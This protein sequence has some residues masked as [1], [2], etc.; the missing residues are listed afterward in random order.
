MDSY[1]TKKVIAGFEIKSISNIDKI[2]Q[3]VYQLEHQKTGAQMVHLANND[4]HNAFGVG[5]LTCPQDSSGIAHI[6]E[7]I[8]LCGSKHF[9]L[10]DPFFSMLKRS[11]ASFMNAFTASDWTMY[12][13]VTQNKKDFYHLLDVY[14]DAVFYPLLKESSFLQEAHRLL[15]ENKKWIAQGVVFN[16]MKGAMS[17]PVEIMSRR[18]LQAVFPSITYHYNS[19]GEPVN[20][21]DLN[22]QS[23]KEF[24]SKYYHPSN[25]KFFSYGSFDLVEK[26]EFLDK[27]ILQNYEKLADKIFI[28]KE[29]RFIS[30]QNFEYY[31]PVAK[32]DHS[33]YQLALNWLNCSVTD[34]KEVLALS[35]LSEILLGSSA[36]PLRFRLVES[37]LGK[38]LADTTGY[39]ED[40][41]ETFFSV[42]LKGIKKQDLQKVENLIL[43]TLQDLAGS[44][45]DKFFIDSAIHQKEI[46]MK[47][48]S[49]S[50]YPYSLNLLFRFIGV[51]MNQGD[52]IASLNFDEALQAI[53]EQA[54]KSNYFEQ[55]ITKHL[56]DNRHRVKVLLK[57]QQEYLLLQDAKIEQKIQQLTKNIE[58]ASKQATKRVEDLT[59]LPC[60]ELQEVNLD[61]PALKIQKHGAFSSS[62]QT[63]NDIEYWSL[64]LENTTTDFLTSKDAAIITSMLTEI[65]TQNFRY[66]QFTAQ[67][68][69]YTGGLGFAPFFSN[70][71]NSENY[72]QLLQLSAKSLVV[73]KKKMQE[74]IAEVL[75]NYSFVNLARIR[76]WLEQITL[77]KTTSLLHQGHYYAQNLACRNFSVIL[78]LAESQFGIHS[79]A[80]LKE[81]TRFSNEKLA[82]LVSKFE[83][84]WSNFLKGARASFCLVGDNLQN[85]QELILD[86]GLKSQEQWSSLSNRHTQAPLKE[87]W[88]MP[89]SVSFVARAYLTVK[90]DHLDSPL[91]LLLAKLVQANFI[92]AE[93]REKGGAYG[94]IVSFRVQCG[95]FCFISY[96]DPNLA[97]TWQ[98]YSRAIDWIVAGKFTR[99]QIKDAILQTFGILDKPLSPATWAHMD[100]VKKMVGMSYEQEKD[101][102]RQIL[103]AS[104]DDLIRVA[105]K[106]L[107]KE[108]YSD[109]AI[110]SKEKIT[111]NLTQDY[112]I[113]TVP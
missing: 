74:L 46:E 72:C 83:N 89:T 96:R 63:T 65:G 29:K 49:S 5:F 39:H 56:L 1:S 52:L 112:N 97:E 77:E 58:P 11:L 99:Q 2:K 103:T 73:N 105:T 76:Q 81:I 43:A 66:E 14:T 48:I 23:L 87:I 69:R 3:K 13:F 86:L 61:F 57:P 18:T 12:P 37:K 45:I 38:D 47:E 35:L 28:P 80:R 54:S 108:N 25:A 60:L 64:Y 90:A 102:R 9:P 31:Y 20:I 41:S 94:G 26:L 34:S 33:L 40:Y 85:T 92:H 91:L 27:K 42:G 24:H 32:E 109:V 22:L 98:V 53:K 84:S 51:W 17:S 19:G 101:Y 100:F 110:S 95:S 104:K 30:P 93:I 88:T 67:V 6:L 79:L 8:V 113:I 59:C 7:H 15:K 16:E 71:I 75:W 10:K 111:A 107:T 50:R 21:L 70:K 78:Q 4:I 68:N 55:L 106:W 62:I 36:A 44:K 82:Q